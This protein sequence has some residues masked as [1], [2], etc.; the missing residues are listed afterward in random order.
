[1]SL[2]LGQFCGSVT[3]DSQKGLQLG[4]IDAHGAENLPDTGG[5]VT[6]TA[7]RAIT[8]SG[9]ITSKGL[10]ADGE[11]G[12]IDFE[13][14]LG[15]CRHGSGLRSLRPK[16][17]FR[18]QASPAQWLFSSLINARLVARKRL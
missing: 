10:S 17:Y 8:I 12:Y 16:R 3:F 5:D 2:G 11:G 13:A 9:V 6:G 18:L 7:G 4:N 1:M 14:G 15:I